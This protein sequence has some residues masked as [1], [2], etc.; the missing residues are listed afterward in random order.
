MSEVKKVLMRESDLKK[1]EDEKIKWAKKGLETG[2][3]IFGKLYPNGLAHVTYVS[4]G[5]PN[6]SRTHISYSGD[7]EY[8][9]RLQEEL[10]MQDP[11]IVLLGEYHVHPWHGQANLSGGDIN[12]LVEVKRKRDWFFVLLNTLDDNAIW[13]VETDNP[14]GMYLFGEWKDE[15]G[16]RQGCR[17]IPP[18]ASPKKLRCQVV[19]D[20]ISDKERLLDRILKI[21]KSEVLIGKK[22]IIVGVGSGGSVIAKY[23]GCTGIGQIILID[24]EELEVENLIRH[25][26]GIGEI[27]KLKVEIC[28]QIIESHNPFTVVETYSFDVTKSYDKLCE[29]AGGADLIIGASGSMRVNNILNGLSLQFN[30]PALYGGV[31]EKGS[32]GFVLAVKPFEGP[33]LNCL[34]GLTSKSYSVDKEA[35]RNY[36][37]DEEELHKQQGLWVD[38]SFPALILTKMAI[39]I[40][41]GNELDYNLVVYRSDLELKKLKAARRKDCAACNFENWAEKQ[42]EEK[43]PSLRFLFEDEEKVVG[44]KE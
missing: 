20:Q 10:Q 16:V 41:E 5:G 21:M 23:L 27:G 31:F 4:D 34:F 9:T 11:E 33:C 38:I 42:L 30:K 1:I 15:T 25:E 26:G 12:Q 35:A 28:K 37:L 3:Y 29:L 6:A 14:A 2:G 19:K 8:A 24:P 44:E 39:A 22:V 18:R 17:Y 43:I 13:D 7:N 40:L 32:G 36:G